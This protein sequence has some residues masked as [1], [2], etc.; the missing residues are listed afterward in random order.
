[1]GREGRTLRDEVNTKAVLGFTDEFEEVFVVVVVNKGLQSSRLILAGGGVFLVCCLSPETA[2][3]PTVRRASKERGG[4]RARETEERG[5][6]CIR[7]DGEQGSFSPSWTMRR[8]RKTAGR[9]GGSAP[10]L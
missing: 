2:L 8:K 7:H 1:M 4:A 6:L 5:A 10:G 3:Q 9:G